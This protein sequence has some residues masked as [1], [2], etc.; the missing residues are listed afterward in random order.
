MFALPTT[1][2]RRAPSV[3]LATP[4][5]A[6]TLA[7][8]GSDAAPTASTGGPSTSSSTSGGSS[9]GGQATADSDAARD[10]YDLRLAQCMRDRGLDIADPAPGEGITEGGPE[11]DAAASACMAEIGDPPVH[12]WTDEELAALRE[13]YLAMAECFRDLGYDAE[14]PAPGNAITLPEGISDADF[15]HCEQAGQ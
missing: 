1:T 6:L 13:R 14:D 5:L 3:L 10:A 7:A 8:C 12:A 2:L 9:S 11:V 15:Q 4:V